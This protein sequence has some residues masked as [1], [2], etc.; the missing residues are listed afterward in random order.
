MRIPCVLQEAVHLFGM[1]K[2]VVWDSTQEAIQLCGTQKSV[3]EATMNK[4]QVLLQEC[5]DEV[6]SVLKREEKC[7]VDGQPW[8]ELVDIAQRKNDL[9]SMARDAL[10]KVWQ[11]ASMK[12]TILLL[13]LQ[14]KWLL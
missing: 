9:A 4:A 8:I 14:T 3:V 2:G 10:E 13:L 6:K 7:A 1:Q 11:N 5:Q 12:L